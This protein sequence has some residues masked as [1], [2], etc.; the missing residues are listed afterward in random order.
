MKKRFL[1]FLICAAVVFT[2]LVF[3][4]PGDWVDIGTVN[5]NSTDVTAS[6]VVNKQYQVSVIGTG[7]PG[8]DSARS[9]PSQAL[10][11]VPTATSDVV[12]NLLKGQGLD[13]VKIGA[14]VKYTWTAST[15]DVFKDDGTK[16]TYPVPS[17]KVSLREVV[18]ISQCSTPGGPTRVP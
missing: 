8:L 12:I 5:I 1:L 3:A 9:D 18:R 14:A 2:P 7:A 15:Y 4:A 11:I 10:S 16:V 17:Y 13:V 6:V